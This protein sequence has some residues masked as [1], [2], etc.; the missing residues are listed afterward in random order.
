MLLYNAFKNKLDNLVDTSNEGNVIS[1]SQTRN[2]TSPQLPDIGR[3]IVVG[4][5]KRGERMEDVNGD[6][7]E[8]CFLDGG[9]I[10]YN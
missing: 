8:I 2:T 6:M 9:R 7:F 4:H 10:K 3:N 1:N 5:F